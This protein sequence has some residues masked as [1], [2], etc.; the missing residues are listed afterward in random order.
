MELKKDKI[1]EGE[2]EITDKVEIPNVIGMKLKEGKKL[3][4]EMGL[5]IEVLENEK[6]HAESDKINNTETE[7]CLIKEQIPVSG[8]DVLK[9]T[10]VLIK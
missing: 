4:E 2:E 1:E 5:A 9:G 3:L 10:K 7:E 6:T 8:V